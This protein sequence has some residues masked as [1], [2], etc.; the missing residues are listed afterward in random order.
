LTA[1]LRIALETPEVEEGWLSG[2]RVFV[3]AHL[4]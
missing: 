1:A 2:E 4:D 3:P